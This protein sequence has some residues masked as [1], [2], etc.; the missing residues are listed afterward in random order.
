[1]GQVNYYRCIQIFSTDIKLI[2]YFIIHEKVIEVKTPVSKKDYENLL[3]HADAKTLP[4]FKTRR[5]FMHKNQQYQLDIYRFARA[6]HVHTLSLQCNVQNTPARSSKIN[7]RAIFQG[8]V[9]RQVPRPHDAG[10]FLN[11]TPRRTEVQNS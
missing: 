3:N 5:V 10:D 7:I 9:S 8:P 2:V 4:V 6:F 1:M 11:A